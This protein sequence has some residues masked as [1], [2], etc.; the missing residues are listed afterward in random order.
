M[1][2]YGVEIE[3][4]VPRSIGQHGVA[5]GLRALGLDA[6]P[7]P[8]SGS[9]YWRWQIKTDGS[10][11]SAPPGYVGVEV[12]S[13]ILP[14]NAD[15][16]PH[17]ELRKVS[18]YLVGIDARVNAST[19]GHVHIDVSHLNAHGLAQLVENYYGSH[20][21]IDST[22]APH[23]RGGAADRIAHDHPARWCRV[24]R[25]WRDAVWHLRTQGTGQAWR[26]GVHENAINADHY[27]SRGTLE[28]RQ[29]DGSIN[30]HKITGWVGFLMGMIDAADSAAMFTFTDADA[31]TDWLVTGGY[32][33]RTLGDHFL[34]RN[35]PSISSEIVSDLRTA[36][37]AATARVSRLMSL[38]GVSL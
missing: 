6:V 36:R 10:L 2:N 17:E 9:E 34:K 37:N 15:G 12:V 7:A 21:A 23:R 30:Y 32:L 18:E 16:T 38:Q 14:W 27:A 22:I 24:N 19:G 13:R 35:L 20:A 28:F 4:Y 26:I 11:R 1:P 33:S 31:M 8:Y 3:C 29:R 5:D 25:D